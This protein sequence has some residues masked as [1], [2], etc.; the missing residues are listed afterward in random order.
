LLSSLDI[1]DVA[2]GADGVA[3]AGAVAGDVTDGVTGATS[4]ASEGD[5]GVLPTDGP[6]EG[7]ELGDGD[8]SSVGGDGA[9]DG[10]CFF[11]HCEQ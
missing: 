4:G 11:Q 9:N 7:D 2:T 1:I 6:N 3:A 5:G 8:L 10:F